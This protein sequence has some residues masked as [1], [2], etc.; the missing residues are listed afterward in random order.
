MRIVINNKYG[1]FGLSYEGVMKYGELKGIKLYAF[2]EKRDDKGNLD[3][4]KFVQYNGTGE[5]PFIIHY[6]RKPL[7]NE[8]YEEDAYFS[9]RDIERNDSALIQ[10]VEELQEKANDICASLKIIEI[11]DDI[12][13]EIEEYDGNEWVSEK[14]QTWC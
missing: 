10:V 3:F 5:K 13:W 12:D 6:S 9:D 1:G 8:T 4:H 7:K 2:T 14:H 11:P